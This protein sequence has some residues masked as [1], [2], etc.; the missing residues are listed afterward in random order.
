MPKILAGI[1]DTQELLCRILSKVDLK[2]SSFK[3]TPIQRMSEQLLS[4]INLSTH[5]IWDL[6]LDTVMKVEKAC[7]AM[8]CKV[9]NYCHPILS[10][11]PLRGSAYV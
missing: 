8:V 4:F 1:M 11:L 7:K 10:E 6:F 9:R 2:K 5:I 3:T